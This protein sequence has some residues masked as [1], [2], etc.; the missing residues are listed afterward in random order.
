MR[1]FTIRQ[2]ELLTQLCH[3]ANSFHLGGLE[4][5]RDVLKLK[6]WKRFDP[7]VIEE[8]E[9]RFADIATIGEEISGLT[10]KL[11]NSRKRR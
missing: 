8:I 10:C 3:D 7:I 6:S 1:P 5:K 2:L 4:K 9:K 11:K